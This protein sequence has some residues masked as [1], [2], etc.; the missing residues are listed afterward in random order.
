MEAVVGEKGRRGG[1]LARVE[2][3]SGMGR[4]EELERW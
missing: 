1:G 4:P 2:G 3:I